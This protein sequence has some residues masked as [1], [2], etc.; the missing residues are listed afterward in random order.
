[1]PV[2]T[3]FADPERAALGHGQDL[4]GL[5]HWLRPAGADTYALDLY[6]RAIQADLP[7]GGLF[8]SLQ[9]T[10]QLERRTD[11]HTEKLRLLRSFARVGNAYRAAAFAELA[12]HYEH[13]KRDYAQA[14]EPTRSAPQYAT[15]R[16]LS[17]RESRLPRK[18]ADAA[19]PAPQSAGQAVD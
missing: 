2:R 15:S 7:A 10:V 3:S 8:S 1:M 11:N 4:L 18:A 19:R 13:R 16:Q 5:A 9:E 12:E 14:L 17:H 6:R